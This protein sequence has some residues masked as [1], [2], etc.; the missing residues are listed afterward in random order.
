MGLMTLRMRGL[1]F[2]LATVAVSLAFDQLAKAY[3]GLTGGDNGLSLH[4]LGNSLVAAQWRT[5]E[6]FVYAGLV[7]V[8]GYYWITRLILGSQLGLE[9]RSVRDDETAAAAAGVRVFRTKVIGFVISAAMT[10][11]AGSLYMQFYQA[12]DPETAFGLSQAIQLQLPALIGGLGTASGPIIGG[13]VMTLLAEIT[14]WGSTKFGLTGVD[15]LVYGLL[16]L[17]VILRAP[18][19]IAGLLQRPQSSAGRGR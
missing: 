1:F 17:V 7:F 13:A 11:L 2:A 4:F 6:P 3:V 18:T 8:I 19:G 14:N 15:V 9:L 5:P 12:I 16:L 10:S